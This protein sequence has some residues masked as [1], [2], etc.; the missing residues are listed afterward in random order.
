MSQTAPAREPIELVVDASIPRLYVTLREGATGPG[1][2]QALAELYRRQPDLAY[3]DKLYDLM[4]YPGV[5]S[6]AD[7]L[8]IVEAYRAANTNPLHPCR[9][10]FVTFDPYFGLWASAMSQLFPGREHRAFTSF[11]K[12]RAFLDEP[13]DQRPPFVTE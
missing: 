13:M 6:H 4:E 2:G 9:T 12:A 11:D 1:V 7:L 8:P 10:A 5:V 3:L